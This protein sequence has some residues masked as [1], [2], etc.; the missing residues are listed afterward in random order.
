MYPFQMV[1]PDNLQADIGA[2]FQAKKSYWIATQSYTDVGY[3]LEDEF[4]SGDWAPNDFLD[5]EP[6]PTKF[7]SG[8]YKHDWEAGRAP[9]WTLDEQ[10]LYLED[11][12]NYVHET[13]NGKQPM[14]LHWISC[15]EWY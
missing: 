10:G 1:L 3:K 6:D 4:S 9:F 14:T 2:C 13:L 7:I 12:V 5:V 8:F 11:I 15:R